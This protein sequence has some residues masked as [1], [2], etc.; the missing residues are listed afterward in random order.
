MNC[1]SLTSKDCPLPGDSIG[2]PSTSE[3]APD[4]PP[5]SDCNSRIKSWIVSTRFRYLAISSR[6]TSSRF[7]MHLLVEPKALYALAHRLQAGYLIC[8]ITWLSLRLIALMHSALQRVQRRVYTPQCAW[9]FR[10]LQSAQTPA[11]V[12]VGPFSGG[13]AFRCPKGVW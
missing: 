7:I 3:E 10:L 4:C 9:G 8:L 5:S 6:T 2:S 11:H 12:M 13:T 1:H